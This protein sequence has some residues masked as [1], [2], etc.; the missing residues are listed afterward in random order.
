MIICTGTIQS[1]NVS[2]TLKQISKIADCCASTITVINANKT[3]GINHI[4][5][6]VEHAT[7]SFENH[8]AI[9]RTF[10]MEI[11]VYVSGQRQCSIASKFGLH[12]GTNSVYIVIIGEDEPRCKT[13]L[14][15]EIVSLHPVKPAEI[16]E[17]MKEYSITPKELE[18]VGEQ[19]IEEL[20]IERVALV[21]AIK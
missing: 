4:E 21:D 8:T 17:L 15:A 5:T 16:S 2:D 6:A 3:A 19:R 14:A 1:D 12:T 10:P 7:R 13:L 11:L 18:I 9:A 20:V